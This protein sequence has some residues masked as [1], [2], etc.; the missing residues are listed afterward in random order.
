[1]RL[2]RRNNYFSNNGNALISILILL[3]TFSTHSVFSQIE[4]SKETTKK[5]KKKKEKRVESEKDGAT[6]IF[7]IT[8]WSFTNSR[9]ETNDGLIGDSLGYRANETG[10][11]TWSF[12]IGFRNRL[13]K[14][15]VLEGG[16]SFMRNGESYSFVEADTSYSYQ[17]QYTYIAMPIRGM[18]SY[19]DKIEFLVG[20]GIVPQLF[21]AYK[22]DRQWTT[23]NN[24]DGS[25]TFKTQNG[26][27]TF[28]ISAVL[29]AG[30]QFKMSD[31]WSF[32]FLPEYKIQLNTSFVKLSPYKH[33]ARSLGF[34]FGL[35]V[36]L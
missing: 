4:L 18:Y 15:F 16:V 28:V 2:S 7:L 8:N 25:E 14:N 36:Q 31:S 6:S 32:L 22:Q 30:V 21:V 33:F 10:L 34:N 27:N 5:E 12:G 24:T 13:H 17:T 20:G 35:V 11:N 9:L 3:I 19:G 26:F 1:M 23:S 29:N